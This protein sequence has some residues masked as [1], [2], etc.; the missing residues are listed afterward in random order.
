MT[1]AHALSGSVEREAARGAA[2]LADLGLAPEGPAVALVDE[3][4]DLRPR[5][6]PGAVVTSE[7]DGEPPWASEEGGGSAEGGE[8]S[9]STGMGEW[10][11]GGGEGG[12]VAVSS[13]SSAESLSSG[14]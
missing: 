4:F 13:E 9:S 6:L 2:D 14:C 11:A 5:A 1:C 3:G 12:G 7:D 8:S 10:C